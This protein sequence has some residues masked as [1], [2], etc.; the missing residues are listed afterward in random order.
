[1]DVCWGGGYVESAGDRT[2]PGF[3]GVFSHE[4]LKQSEINAHW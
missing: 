4:S 3:Q 1:M 2:A